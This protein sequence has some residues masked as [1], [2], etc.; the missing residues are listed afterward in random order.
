MSRRHKDKTAESLS[1]IAHKQRLWLRN[2]KNWHKNVAQVTRNIVWL[3]IRT[4][5]E[6]NAMNCNLWAYAVPLILI[7]I[8]S[9]PETLL[10]TLFIICE[11]YTYREL[12]ILN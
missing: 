11:S 7:K 5:K 9:T 2:R 1:L 3:T 4:E 8:L 12:P 10:P 6:K